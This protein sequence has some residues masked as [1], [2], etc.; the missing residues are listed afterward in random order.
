MVNGIIPVQSRYR[1]TAIPNDSAALPTMSG[2]L[3]IRLKND[4]AKK[5]NGKNSNKNS[6]K[7][8]ATGMI[9]QQKNSAAN[10]LDKHLSAAFEKSENRR[11]TGSTATRPRLERIHFAPKYD[12][13]SS[14]APIVC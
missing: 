12:L 14:N 10:R 7:N 2:M 1:K 5:T 11:F 13:S 4:T 9:G 8:F 3:S 6:T